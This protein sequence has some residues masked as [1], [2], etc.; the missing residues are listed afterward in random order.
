VRAEGIRHFPS[1]LVSAL[2][3]PLPAIA[4][5]MPEKKILIVDNE[6]ELTAVLKIALEA[7]GGFRVLSENDPS[8]A[9]AAA[10]EFNP[11]LIIMDIKMPGLDGADVAIRLKDEPSLSE[12]PIVF[13]TG[14]VTVPEIVRYGRK[15]GG[16]RL[17]PKT[18]R[19][20]AMVACLNDI[21]R[22]APESPL[23]S[24]LSQR[25]A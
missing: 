13:L 24:G 5:N 14:A 1:P 19:L 17:L 20:D 10:N 12:T 15:I 16:L 22:G 21:L 3:V 6:P 23:P 25:A 8:H 9:A 7:L 11:D 18:M 2:L 4:M